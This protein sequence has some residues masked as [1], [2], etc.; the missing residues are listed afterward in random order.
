MKIF[1]RSLVLFTIL[2]T[3]LMLSGCAEVKILPKVIS[4][5]EIHS[6]TT[7]IKLSLALAG[8]TILIQVILSTFG[9][10]F[11]GLISWIILAVLIFMNNKM[12]IGMKIG[13]LAS[14]IAL[15]IIIN[16]LLSLIW[17]KLLGLITRK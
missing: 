11:T 10:P 16:F 8:M 15:S 9:I 6:F 1:V 12:G 13:F 7:F 14:I 2:F 3:S 4:A 5:I 17:G